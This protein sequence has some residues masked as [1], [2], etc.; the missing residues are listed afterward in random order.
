M[1]V[2]F[3]KT[4]YY[5]SIL[6]LKLKKIKLF[7]FI[8]YFFTL[9]LKLNFNFFLSIL[10]SENLFIAR[11]ATLTVFSK[12]SGCMAHI[13]NKIKR[14]LCRDPQKSVLNRVGKKSLKG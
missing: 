5:H 13:H 4:L 6:P 11:M 2:Q 7:N 1:R 12:M 3:T 10:K 14:N 8:I 9:N